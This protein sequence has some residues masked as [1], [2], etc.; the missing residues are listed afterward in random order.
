LE[1]NGDLTFSF[2]PDEESSGM[3]KLAWLVD[4]DLVKVRYRASL[5]SLQPHLLKIDHRGV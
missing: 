2:P 4:K 1:I 3:A 5:P